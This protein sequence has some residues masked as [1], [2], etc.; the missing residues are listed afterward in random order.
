MALGRVGKCMAVRARPSRRRCEGPDELGLEV[1]PG[2]HHIDHV[3][4]ISRGADHSVRNLRVI[5]KNE[6]EEEFLRK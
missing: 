6:F 1:G 2:E 3:V 4:P 5:E